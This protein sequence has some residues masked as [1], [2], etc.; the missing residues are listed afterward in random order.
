MIEKGGDCEIL[1]KCTVQI[2]LKC[3][4]TLRITPSQKKIAIN[5]DDKQ[6][7]KDD[8]F[9]Q[10]TYMNHTSIYDL[11]NFRRELKAAEIAER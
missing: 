6:F 11:K 9:K 10:S 8:Y 3:F 5:C 4:S 7:M 2:N 1:S